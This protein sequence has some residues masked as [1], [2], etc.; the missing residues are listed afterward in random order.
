MHKSV[1]GWGSSRPAPMGADQARLAG[2]GLW[3]VGCW[4]GGRG[5]P[6][7]VSRWEELQEVGR[8]VGRHSVSHSKWSFWRLVAWLLYM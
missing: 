6:V 7:E 8:L 2:E 4:P 1:R 3:E 5:A